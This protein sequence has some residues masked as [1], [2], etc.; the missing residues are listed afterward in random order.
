MEANAMTDDLIPVIEG[1]TKPDGYTG[2]VEQHGQ[3]WWMRIDA[4]KRNP[5]TT[6][7]FR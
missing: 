2:L 1:E 7:L 6:P 4:L 5:P 3:R